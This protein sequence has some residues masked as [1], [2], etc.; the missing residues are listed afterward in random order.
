MQSVSSR[1]WTRVAVFISYDD[2]NYTTG[3]SILLTITTSGCLIIMIKN[4]FPSEMTGGFSLESEWQ[5]VSSCLD[6]SE[7]SSCGL[8][9]FDPF[10]GFQFLYFL[11]QAFEEG[12]LRN[13][14]NWYHR[15]PYITYLP[16]FS[17]FFFFFFFFSPCQLFVYLFAFFRF[18]SAVSW[19]SK[20]HSVTSSFLLAN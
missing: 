2:N 9:S 19:N 13:N 4:F 5:Q 14:Y 10:T 3:T 6:S 20:I 11:F 7:Y 1:I 16:F 17:S 18:H 15:H 8:Y 12:S